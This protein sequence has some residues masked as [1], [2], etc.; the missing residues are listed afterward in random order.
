MPK[1]ELKFQNIAVN[2][3]FCFNVDT[4]IG[5]TP[6]PLV[7]TGLGISYTGKRKAEEK[8]DTSRPPPNY[9]ETTSRDN[10][11]G[12]FVGWRQDKKNDS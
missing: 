10:T 5:Y 9:R 2:S 3:V 8:P 12:S 4:R 11:S 7:N 6:E 1:T